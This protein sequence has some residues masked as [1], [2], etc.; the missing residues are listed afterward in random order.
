[1]EKEQ[2]HRQNIDEMQKAANEY[3]EKSYKYDAFISYRHVEPDQSIAK[4]VHQMIETFKAPKEFYQNGKRPVFRVFRDREELAARDLSASIEE[5][6]ATSRYLIVICSKRTPLSEWC[7]REI[8]TFKSLHGSER[9]IP[10]LIEGE[11]GEAFPLPL[12]ELKGEESVSEILAADIRPDETLNADFEGYEALQNNNKAKLKELTKKS[13]DILKTEKYRVMATILGCNFGDLKQ[14]DKERKNKRIMTVSTVA[15]AVFLIFGLFMANA[16]HKAELARQEA[17]QSNAS[18]LMKRSKDFTKEGDFIKAVL[19]AKEAMKSIK[20]NMKYYDTLKA[21]EDTIFNSMIYHSGASTLTSIS[22]KNIFTFMDVSHDEKYVAY[23]LD[24]NYTAIASVDNGE[25]LKI[26]SGHTQPVKVVMFSNNDKYLASYSFDNTCIIYDVETGEERAKIETDGIPMLVRFSEDDSKLILITYDNISTNFYLYDTANWQRTGGFVI[27]ELI[28]RADIKK[29]GSEALIITNS[30]SDDQITRRNIKDGSIIEIIPSLKTNGVDEGVLVNKQYKSATYSA[31]G[32]NILLNTQDE[33]IKVTYDNTEL[34]NQ[35]IF[36][37]FND[38]KVLFESEN[39]DKITIKSNDN[40]YI[41]DGKTGET[42]DKVYKKDLTYYTYNSSTNTI[43]GFLK[44]GNYFIW[45]DGAITESNLNYGGILPVEYI[46][47]KDGSKVLASSHDSQTIKIID[48]KSR[49]SSDSIYARI[50]SNSNDSSKML[51]FDG[52]DVFISE[53]DGKTSRKIPFNNNITYGIAATF[54]DQKISNDGR[55]YTVLGIDNDTPDK[56]PTLSI[57]DIE[58]DTINNVYINAMDSILSFSNDSKQIFVLDAVEGLNVYSTDSFEKV[59]TYSDIREGSGDIKLS[60]DSKIFVVNRYAGIASI[61]NLESG[62]HIEDIPGEVLYVENSS[63]EI[64]AKGIQNNTAFTWSS[65]T[66]LKSWEM[67]E[68]CS[69][70]PLSLKDVNLYNANADILLMIRNNDTERK[71]YVVDFST[72]RLKMALNSTLKEYAVNGHISSD[73]KMIAVDQNYYADYNFNAGKNNQYI[74]STV[75]KILNE[76][77]VSNEIDS[78]L[79]GRILTEDE[80]IQIG[81]TTK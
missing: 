22:T 75:Y 80:K 31:D 71:C 33:L 81:L 1:M 27:D 58:N 62:E 36:S 77:E 64:R 24:N 7:Q 14:R 16:Y 48:L 73:G 43:V 47:L 49:I 41:L 21:E 19:V 11:P 67:D 66:G 39:G 12:K 8:E 44:D 10:V 38:T 34:F 63:G 54:K 76:E 9:I 55:Y 69:Q 61:Y 60:Q 30:G 57:Y 3:K 4:Q 32:E 42:I 70:T 52:N 2:K 79:S 40:I 56:K 65:K 72:G 6:L 50:V 29:D 37:S 17:V 51:L 53:D 26:L 78:I 35:K 28:K 59:K 25:V 74:E 45:K 13:L 5:A 46:F 68:A 15:G 20:P 18:I 23:G